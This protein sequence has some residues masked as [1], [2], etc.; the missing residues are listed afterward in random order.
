MTTTA[1]PETADQLAA[2][3][4]AI[5]Q[6]VTDADALI[7]RLSDERIDLMLQLHDQGW[8]NVQIADCIGLTRQRVSTIL[9]E[10]L[11]A[12]VLSRGKAKGK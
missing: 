10:P 5:S 11:K 6:E 12:R 3:L 7:G 9:A 8:N 2:R 1:P 4:K